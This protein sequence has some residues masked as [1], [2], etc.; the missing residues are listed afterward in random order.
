MYAGVITL[1]GNKLRFS[2]SNWKTMLAIK[3]LRVRLREILSRSFRNPG[4]PL[5]PSLLRWL[6][7]WQRIFTREEGK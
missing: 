4:K 6:E 3:A 2:I 1:D 7:V 5:S